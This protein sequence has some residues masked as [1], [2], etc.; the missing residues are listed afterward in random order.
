MEKEMVGSFTENPPLVCVF[1]KHKIITYIFY[2]KICFIAI[3][4]LQKN[5]NII[6]I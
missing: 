1:A 2:I 4:V 5:I 6:L 3:D